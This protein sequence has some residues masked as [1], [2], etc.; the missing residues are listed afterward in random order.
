MKMPRRQTP[1][2]PTESRWVTSL[3]FFGLL[4]WIDGRPLLDVIEPY[5][6]RHFAQALDTRDERGA[7]RYN[8]I[9]GGRA[10]KNWKSADLIFAALFALVANDS[11]G[12][13]QCYLFANDEDQAG[14]DLALAKKLIEANSF[15]QARL[16]VKQK[17]IE[18]RDGRGFL[19]ILPAQDVFGSHGK[20]CRW[21]GFDEI[22]GYRTWD[23]LEAMQLDPTRP[24]RSVADVVRLDLPQARRAA[25]RPDEVGPR[26]A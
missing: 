18:R 17:V 2:P 8:L 4:L 11:P 5:R 15:L 7:L 26:G 22:H 3:E 9:L 13:N 23:L 10:K 1:T 6:A 24:D 21:E 16:V 14:D 25:V 20:T 12:G 19:K